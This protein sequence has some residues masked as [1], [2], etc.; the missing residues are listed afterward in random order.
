CLR[1]GRLFDD[2]FIADRFGQQFDAEAN[3]NCKCYLDRST[4]GVGEYPDHMFLL[5]EDRTAAV[6]CSGSVGIEL[7]RISESAHMDGALILG[8]ILAL[9]MDR[10]N[11]RRSDAWSDVFLNRGVLIAGLA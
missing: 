6:A 10:L 3:G 7:D 9:L 11:M 8:R 4:R 5:I 1:T 2:G